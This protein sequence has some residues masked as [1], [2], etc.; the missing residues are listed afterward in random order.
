MG[1]GFG[2]RV[3]KVYR[4]FTGYRVDGA[5][6]VHRVCFSGPSGVEDPLPICQQ[7]MYAICDA[8][9]EGTNN[10]KDMNELGNHCMF[11][12]ACIQTSIHTYIHMFKNLYLVTSLNYKAGQEIWG[13]QKG[14]IILRTDHMSTFT[15]FV[16]NTCYV[17][18][19]I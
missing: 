11:I 12:Y 6:W 14:T 19:D 16:L 15:Y 3:Y 18:A 10:H 1:L 7:I 13:N 9:C 8:K 4:V 17:H 5:S 2:F